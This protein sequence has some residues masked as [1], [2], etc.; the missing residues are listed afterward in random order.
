M[1][2]NNIPEALSL[3]L[4]L[5]LISCLVNGRKTFNELKELVE[6][7]DGNISVQLSKLEKWGF[8]IS[9]KKIEGK[10]P[11][12]TYEITDYGIHILKEYVK[13]LESIIVKIE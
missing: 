10:K 2:I 11:R 6:A 3:P 4:R 7:S 9:K 1:D 13:L 8:I 5:K 12:T